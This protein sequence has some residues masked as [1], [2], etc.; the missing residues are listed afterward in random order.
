[1]KEIKMENKQSITSKEAPAAIGPYSQAIK[2]GNM[3]FISGQLPMDAA[4]GLLIEGSIGDKTK[5]A[6]DN[7]GAILKE[8][9]LGFENLVKVTI[10]VIDMGK[11]AEI[12]EEY[13]NYFPGTPP[14]RAVVGVASLPRNAELEIEGIAVG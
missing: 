13:K 14:A 7:V 1:M 12:N 3:L 6:L 9:G 4:T 2:A 10:F 5:K 11:F 8:A